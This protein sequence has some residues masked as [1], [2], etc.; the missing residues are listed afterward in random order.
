MLAEQSSKLTLE[1]GTH[2][3]LAPPLD[4]L[5]RAFLP[6]INRMGPQVVIQSDTFGFYPAGGGRFEAEITPVSKLTE[7]EVTTRSEIR[8]RRATV[9]LA[10]LPAHIAERELTTLRELLPWPCEAFTC[11]TDL[12]SPGPGNAIIVEVGC[13]E[14]TEVFSAFGQKGVRAEVVIKELIH[15]VRRYLSSEAPVGE[16]LADQLLLP[17]ALAGAGRFVTMGLTR[18]SRTNME[19]IARFLPVRFGIEQAEPSRLT[20]QVLS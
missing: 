3:P 20:V 5:E 13:E 19:V 12:P 1:G 15:E 14:V 2:N 18:H 11:E 6:L 9:L 10:N 4:F 17:M 7:L 8:H 16:H